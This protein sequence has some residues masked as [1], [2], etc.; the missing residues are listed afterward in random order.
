[1][2]SRSERRKE[3]QNRVVTDLSFQDLWGLLSLA[4]I[5]SLRLNAQRSRPCHELEFV[6]WNDTSCLEAYKRREW[7]RWWWWTMGLGSLV[8]IHS[9]TSV[10]L[11]K[12]NHNT[13]TEH[14]KSEPSWWTGIESTLQ[15]WDTHQECYLGNTLFLRKKNQKSKIKTWSIEIRVLGFRRSSRLPIRTIDCT[16]LLSE[17]KKKTTTRDQ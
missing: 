13:S 5:E 1:M 2:S 4:V 12:H 6:F 7:Y 8:Y 15:V 9:S 11:F 10:D 17:K 16:T 3:K 14:V